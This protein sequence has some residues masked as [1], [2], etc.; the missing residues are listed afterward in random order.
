MD[1]YFGQYFNDTFL[2]SSLIQFY[3]YFCLLTAT[4]YQ[5]HL[6]SFHSIVQRDDILNGNNLL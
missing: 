2:L 4:G 6:Y 3:N 1:F 5:D